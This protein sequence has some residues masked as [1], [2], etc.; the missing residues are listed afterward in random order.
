MNV[1][2]PSAEDAA[3]VHAIRAAREQRD[4]GFRVSTLEDLLDAW[5]GSEFNLAT[6]AAV[7][8]AG[9]EIIGYADVRLIGSLTFVAPMHEGRGAGAQLLAWTE[10]RERALGRRPHRQEIASTNASGALLLGTAGYGRVRSYAQMSRALDDRPE[11]GPLPPGVTLRPIDV[12]RDAIALHA[13]DDLAFRDRPDYHAETPES[14]REEHLEAY[15]HEPSLGCVAETDGQI[16]GFA[17][18]LAWRHE[19]VGFIDLLAVHPEH[20]R[21]GIASAMLRHVFAAFA[22]AGLERALLGVASDNPRALRLYEGVGM[23]E[24][25]RWDIYERPIEA[26]SDAST[27]AA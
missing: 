18:S 24:A 23:T 19:P 1:R 15:N 4:F 5:G 2:A 11:L 22:D 8:D 9:G 16:V 3:A 13:L 14:F 10:W 27:P 12:A 21:V 6:D 25:Y 7:A 26:G 17:C 20:R